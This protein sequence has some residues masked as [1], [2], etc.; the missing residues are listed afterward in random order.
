MFREI[1][2]N[3]KITA[4]LFSDRLLTSYSRRAI[5]T[6]AAFFL[7]GF[8]LFA[9][10]TPD[11]LAN[12]DAAVYAQQI[13]NLDLSKRSVHIGY[14]LAGIAFTSLV[15]GPD[16]Y[17]LNLMNG[18]FGAGTMSLIYLLTFSI[19][20]RHLLATVSTVLLTANYIFVS[21]TLYAEVY[22]PQTFFVVLAV[23]LW[24]L[25]RP[26]LTGLSLVLAIMI[27]PSSI[28]ALPTFAILRPERHA[29]VLLAATIITILPITLLTL[30]AYFSNDIVD[31]LFGSRGIFEVFVLTLRGNSPGVNL[32]SAFIKEGYEV[33]LG[34]FVFVPFVVTGLIRIITDRSLLA[35]AVAV[36]SLWLFTF[37]FG[38]KFSDVPVQLPT[39]A[40]LCVVGGLGFGFILDT[41]PST[42]R[43]RLTYLGVLGLS[44]LLVIL[45]LLI[46]IKA[47]VTKT[48]S[49]ISLLIPLT[50]IL[51]IVLFLGVVML[52][53]RSASSQMGTKIVVL[54]AFI[55][56]AGINGALALTLINNKN[57]DMV[58]Y[59]KLVLEVD[60]VASPNYLIIGGFNHGILFEHYL[61]QESHLGDWV[62]I[63]RAFDSRASGHKEE[64]QRW[65]EAIAANREIWLLNG[66]NYYVE[67]FSDLE[68]SG[69]TI[70]P[71]GEIY[72]ARKG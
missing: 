13:E 25:K 32:A 66:W 68:G 69:Y 58:E 72:V 19:T 34:F 22:G 48:L 44:S 41:M 31:Y 30:S 39:Y 5:L 24:L 36:F 20:R 18:F 53:S 6:S 37:G 47:D 3:W 60:R 27:I 42:G 64:I 54:G 65:R 8:I 40:L 15:P 51:V 55:L 45:V 11:A 35:F 71:F 46:G 28:F 2:L 70:E 59:R 63:D 14:F 16:D 57:H 43:R 7:I 50:F 49:E 61:Y 67:A 21:N 1:S 12:G 9:N 33:L 52:L 62:E 4:Q 23:L 29:I 26:V 38:E 10:L 56:V 17:V